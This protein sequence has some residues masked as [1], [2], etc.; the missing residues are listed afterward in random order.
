M[1]Q[2]KGNIHSGE[3]LDLSLT[4]I[5]PVF[6]ADV[7]T[8]EEHTILSHRYSVRPD[9]GGYLVE[10]S[11]GLRIRMEASQ[12]GKMTNYE[13]RDVSVI[14]TAIVKEGERVVISKNGARELSLMVGK[15]GKK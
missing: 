14:G 6:Q 10:Y 7:V 2:L 8:G 11:I 5:G 1:I 3:P 12:N 13:Y 15:A 9:D 4:G